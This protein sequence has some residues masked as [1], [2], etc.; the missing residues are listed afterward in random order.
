MLPGFD[1]LCNLSRTEFDDICLNEINNRLLDPIAF[2]LEDCGLVKSD[3]HEIVL[4]GGTSRVPA[5]RSVIQ[6]FF[7]SKMPLEVAR[8][9]HAAVLGASAYALSFVEGEDRTPS[10]LLG[11]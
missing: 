10:T 9:D 3:I 8:P 1:Y 6:N 4:V 7:H 2:C 5:V 11:Q